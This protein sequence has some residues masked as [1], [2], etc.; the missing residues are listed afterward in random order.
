MT[1]KILYV[2]AAAGISG[3]M[4]LGAL[5]DLEVPVEALH[6][7]WDALGIDHYEVQVFETRKSGLRALRCRVKTAEEKGPRTWKQ[8]QKMI[9]SSK[10]K[11]S[12][13]KRVLDLTR[14]VFEAESYLHKTSLEKL[15]LHEM[16]GLDLMLDVSGVL[17]AIDYLQPGAIYGS[18]IN[19]GKGFVTF[20]HGTFPVPAPATAKLLTG[21][22]VFQND[23]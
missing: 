7:T 19:T 4:F 6:A 8:Y 10:L 22:P 3:D 21:I 20:S 16:G 9:G 14:K 5:L 23:F 15:H 2:E 13:K 1:E 12:Q 11:G 17:A 18:P